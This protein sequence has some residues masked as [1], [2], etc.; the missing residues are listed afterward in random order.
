MAVEGIEAG[1]F[2]D[3][4]SGSNVDIC[5]ITKDK[6]T[7]LRNYV[8]HDRKAQEKAAPYHFPLRDTPYLDEVE[9]KMSPIEREGEEREEKMELL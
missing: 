7:Y 6:C 1:I 2:H 8:S 5:V 4:G 3:M 9:Y